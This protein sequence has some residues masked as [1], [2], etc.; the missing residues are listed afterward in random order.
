MNRWFPELV[1]LDFDLTCT[2]RLLFYD[3]LAEKRLANQIIATL[4]KAMDSG[5]GESKPKLTRQ[6][7]NIDESAADY[8]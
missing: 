8:W 1:C 5:G 2:T 7:P 3:L 6:H 4:S